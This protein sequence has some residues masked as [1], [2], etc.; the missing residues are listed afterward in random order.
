MPL[1]ESW[2]LEQ[3]FSFTL[4]LA[5]ISGLVAITP[6]LGV[7]E[8][9]RQLRAALAIVLSLLLTPLAARSLAT[10]PHTLV[11]YLLLA[12]SELLIGL[13][14]G[15]GLAILFSGMYLAGQLISQLSG[16]SLADVFQP[17]LDTS[18]PLFS[19]LLFYVSSAVFVLTGGH[20][21]V[22]AAL[23]ETLVT[24]PP[25]TLL[26]PRPAVETLTTL[27]LQSFVLGIRAAAPMISALVL[28]TIVLGLVSRTVPQINIIAVGFGLNSLL[29]LGM[30]FVSLGALAWIFQEQ[31]DAA[32]ERLHDLLASIPHVTL[33]G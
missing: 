25:G 14:L 7:Q 18:L 19:Q 3:F 11:D 4:V 31:C 26:D 15:L 28:A 9:P 20:R 2:L 23:V 8:L 1:L 5:R 27:L 12:G 13:V 32:L 6:I 16:L 33:H 10:L 30:L 22:V 21:A 29:T 24:M 17:D